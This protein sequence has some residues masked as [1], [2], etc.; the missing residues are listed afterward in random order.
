MPDEESIDVAPSAENGNIPVDAPSEP[1]LET[2]VPTEPTEP[3][4]PTAV[5]PEL[6]ELPDGRKVDAPTLSKE[7]KENFLPEFTR[8]SQALA[9]KDNAPLQETKS[10]NP[11]A[12]PDYVPQTYAEIVELAKQATFQEMADKEKARVDAA[13]AL[14]TTVNTQLSE[15]KATDPNLNENALFVHA[16]KY[17]FTDLKLAHQNMKDMNDTIKKV[18]QTTA[19]NIQKRADPVSVSPGATGAKLNPDQFGSSLEYLRALKGT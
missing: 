15:I 16:T 14:E 1:V 7:W 18:Q 8:K 6:Y 4:T 13:N 9:A 17:R 5:E 2:A 10:T 3:V 12:D 19:Q 11:L